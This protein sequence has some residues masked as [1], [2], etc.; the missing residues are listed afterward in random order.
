MSR[1]RVGLAALIAVL[2]LPHVASGQS[3]SDVL[4]FLVTNQGVQTGSADRDR[5]AAQATSETI[6]RAL[7]ADLATLPVATSSSG[8]LYRLNP[9]LGT[10][11][12]VTPNFGPFFVERALTAGRGQMS[13]GVSFQQLHF[14]SLDGSSLRNGSLVTTANQ[15]VGEPAPFDINQLT[16]NIDASV[17]TFYGSL[18]VTDHLEVGVAAPV[19][20]LIV[21]G[22]RN[23]IYR[24]RTFTQATAHATAVG[25]AD[26]VLRAKLNVYSSDASGL[27]GAVDVRLPTG[28]QQDLLGAG[29][30]AV[31]LSGIG[32]FERGR[33]STHGNAG[34]SLGGLATEFDYGGA[35]AVAAS[36]RLTVVG[37]VL[38]RFINTPG[39][40]VPSSAPNPTLQGVETIR[41]L[42][43]DSKLNIVSV[44]PGMKW[45]LTST[46]VLAANVRIPV[47]NAGLTAPVTPFVGLDYEL[48][49]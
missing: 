23:N 16:L 12:R 43:G 38:G 46:W 26:V 4:T 8:F 47:T 41:L 36:G 27:A 22:S 3:L 14:T 10:D 49:R 1:C 15:F 48:G 40:V 35:L 7:L 11:E 20:S 34:F 25:L 21:D 6:S 29:S 33:L 30:T 39:S 37:E 18:G 2:A 9:E 44:I 32:S 5:A 31:K 45:N 24:G 42:P 28:R 19:V 17:A 13:L